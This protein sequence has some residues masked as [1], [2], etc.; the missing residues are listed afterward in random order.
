MELNYQHYLNVGFQFVGFLTKSEMVK[1][2]YKVE[3][4]WMET[5]NPENKMGVYILAKED[6]ILKIGESQNLRH[7]FSCYESHSGPTN[8]M[9]RENIK[10]DDLI[11]ILFLECPSYEVG[12]GGVKVPSGI[13]YRILEKNLLKQYE[14]ETQT[15]PKWNKGKS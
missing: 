3:M 9:I 12:F 7:R 11:S 6:Q 5:F 13:N 2:K 1:K 14:F 15:L 8:V 10:E 4:R